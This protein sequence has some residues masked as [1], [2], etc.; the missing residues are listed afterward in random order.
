MGRVALVT[1]GASGIGKA[2][3]EGLAAR[4][5]I[6]VV[7]DVNGDGAEQ[8]AHAIRAAGGRATAER[9]DVTSAEAVAACVQKTHAA[10]GRLDLLFNNAGICVMGEAQHHTPADWER[11]L[12]VNVRGVL[13]GIRAAYPLMIAQGFGHLVN[14][15]SVSALVP[16][17]LL[18][19][20]SM[21]KHAVLGLSI[22]LRPEAARY[23]VRV[24]AVCP[25][26]IRTGMPQ[27]AVVRGLKR[28]RMLGSIPG[29]Y[30]AEDAARDILRGVDQNREI[31]HV[32]WFARW[33]HRLRRW[34]PGLTSWAA[35]LTVR[36]TLR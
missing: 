11:L 23:G 28:E 2:L 18:A 29:W 3:C 10:H 30:S 27:G 4:G 26:F 34:A 7:T 1:G 17:P 22:G 16:S 20:Y 6:V 32:Q 33:T 24:S 25:G 8:V 9:L 13:H 35:A 14:I 15:S 12:D 36:R 21:T 19:G 5:D 31:I